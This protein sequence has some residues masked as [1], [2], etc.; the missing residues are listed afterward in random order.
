MHSIKRI[1]VLIIFF[2][3]QFSATNKILYVDG[4]NNILGSYNRENQLLEF[5]KE[6]NIQTLILYN[7][8]KINKRIPLSD[9]LKNW[10]L[11]AF[12][13]RAKLEYNILE[14]GASGETGDFF[15]K[16]IH[17]YNMS[18]KK[19]IEKFD[20]YNLEYEYWDRKA[21]IN[22]GYYCETYLKKA[23]ISCNRNG[24]FKYYIEALSIMRLLADEGS[25]PIKIEAYIGKFTKKEALK[26]SNYADQLLIHAYVRHPKKSYRYT[27]KRLKF[28]SK[29]NSKIC[30]SIIF[31]AE[32]K[33]MGRWLTKN[34]HRKA[35]EI[36]LK[37]LNKHHKKLNFDGFTYYNYSNFKKAITHYNRKNRNT[38][39]SYIRNE[40]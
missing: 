9:P 30:V 13:S 7:L 22:G 40:Y 1:L 17:P 23:H 20:V 5:S 34:D 18:R 3:I 36:F 21:S 16:A 4:F 35:E 10:V 32:R 31:S 28:L 2:S 33:F 15:L 38:E 26:V 8:H 24:S 39:N 37:K 14:V 12:I 19:A 6:N 27:K 25:H 29:I 11:A